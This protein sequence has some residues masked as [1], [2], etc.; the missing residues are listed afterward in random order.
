MS[1]VLSRTSSVKINFSLSPP[2]FNIHGVPQGSVP[3]SILFIIYILPIK[4]I[5][6]KYPNIHYHL[7]ADDLQIYTSF[8]SSSDSDMIQMSMFKCITDLTEWFS[9][10][11]L[12]LNMTKTDTTIF[13]RPSSPLSIT[14]LFYNLYQL[15]NL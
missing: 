8:P 15:L 1:F 12:S 7:Y 3:G 2:Y 14:H 11:S 9:H 13:S 6:H 10:N 4:S 5:F